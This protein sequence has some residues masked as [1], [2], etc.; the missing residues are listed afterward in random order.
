MM[1]RLGRSPIEETRFSDKCPGK[2]PKRQGCKF[3]SWWQV[4]TFHNET[5]MGRVSFFS[6]VSIYRFAQRSYFQKSMISSRSE[7]C[8]EP[9][10]PYS[11]T[12]MASTNFVHKSETIEYSAGRRHWCA[13]SFETRWFYFS[14]KIRGIFLGRWPKIYWLFFAIRLSSSEMQLNNDVCDSL[15]FSNSTYARDA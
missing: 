12:L 6:L 1:V 11:F 8:E 9:N 15:Q 7:R 2:R 4:A 10:R 13:C 5:I 14:A 3:N